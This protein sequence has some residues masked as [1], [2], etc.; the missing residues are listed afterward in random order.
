[1]KKIITLALLALL[2][3][4]QDAPLAYTP[5]PFAF[6]TDRQPPFSVNVATIKVTDNYRPPLRKPN[7]EQDFP[8]PPALAVRKWADTR[9]K[10]TGTSGVLEISINDA[11]V[12]ES[13]IAKPD[14]VKGVFTKDQAQNNAHLVVNIRLYTGNDAM[15]AA[16]GDVE[17]TR[18]RTINVNDSIYAH[19]QFYHAM[20]RDMMAGYDTEAN[21]I[22]RK[23]FSNYLK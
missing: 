15:S 19:Q 7:V 6:E 22:L 2:T 4:C 1:M 10:A 13:A 17:I 16:S 21:K 20:A 11:S 23:Y 3:A 12:K 9:L 14:G 5:E 8:I 18:S